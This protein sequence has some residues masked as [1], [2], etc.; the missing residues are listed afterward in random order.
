MSRKVRLRDQVSMKGEAEDEKK[1]E[2]EEEEKDPE[3]EKEEKED[4]VE[5]R[6]HPNVELTRMCTPL[7]SK[8]RQDVLRAIVDFYL[9]LRS[10]GYVV[11]QIHTDRGGKFCSEALDDQ[12]LQGKTCHLIAGV[13]QGRSFTRSLQ[14]TN[15]NPMGELRFLSNGSTQRSAECSMLRQPRSQDGLSRQGA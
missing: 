12:G 10:D 14:V 9:R 6:I 11:T 5:E 3:G 1:G 7:P 15:H 4:Q 8:N 13:P 2:A